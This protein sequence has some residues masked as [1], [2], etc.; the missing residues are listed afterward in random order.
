M[1]AMNVIDIPFLSALKDTDAKKASLILSDGVEG[2]LIKNVNWP[3]KY[4]YCPK[5]EFIIAR[6]DNSLYIKFRVSE[7]NVKAVHIKDQEA[8]WEDSC[9]EFFCKK[10]LSDSYNNF[11]FNCIGACVAT[12]RKGKDKDVVPFSE[13]QMMQID[14]FT[15]LGRK[16]YLEKEGSCDWEITVSIPFQLLGI[17][18]GELPEK[19]LGNFYKCAD[20]S[21]TPHYVS[22]NPI[23]TEKPN[24]HRPDFFGE[25]YLNRES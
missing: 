6:S 25:L 1:T 13:S 17:N 18:P 9:V 11:E 22:W 19:L 4:S 21:S 14:R 15:T 12:S 10:P 16:S 24:F 23:S 2:H 5:S 20:G 7:C 8:V 3:E